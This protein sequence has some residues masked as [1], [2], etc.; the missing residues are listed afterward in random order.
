VL[1]IHGRS[2]EVGDPVTVRTPSDRPLFHS[3]SHGTVLSF[4]VSRVK[5]RID[6]A[7]FESRDGEVHTFLPQDLVHGHNGTPRNADRMTEAV[8]AMGAAQVTTAVDLAVGANVITEDQ[9]RRILALW[10]EHRTQR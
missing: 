5:I 8:T 9:G 4:G 6:V 3:G 7:A 10:R 2:L 1:D